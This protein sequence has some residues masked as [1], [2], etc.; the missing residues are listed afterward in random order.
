VIGCASIGARTQIASGVQ[1]LS[2]RYQHTRDAGGGISGADEGVFTMVQIGAD[3]W[4]GAGAI[5]M[6]DIGDGATV[7]AGAV[8]LRPVPPHS[9]AVGNPAHIVKSAGQ[10]AS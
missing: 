3:C 4:I 7:G 5:V 8:V 9:V 1:I 2:G 6:A 10:S